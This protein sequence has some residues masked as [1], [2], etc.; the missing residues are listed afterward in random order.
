MKGITNELLHKLSSDSLADSLASP[1][2]LG[3]LNASSTSK[4][5][6][7]ETSFV[8]QS[9]E[10]LFDELGVQRLQSIRPVGHVCPPTTEQVLHFNT[11][12]VHGQVLAVCL[13][14]SRL[15]I[16]QLH[17]TASPS[18]DADS[19]ITWT[20][21]AEYTG[22]EFRKVDHF[23]SDRKIFFVLAKSG[24][25]MPLLR[26]HLN[27]L[28][29][30]RLDQQ[31][32]SSDPSTI[33]IWLPRTW[34]SNQQGGRHLNAGQTWNLAV[35]NSMMG[36]S[37][38]LPTFDRR[39]KR[40][41]DAESS[42][43]TLSTL[44]LPET[45]P[46][47][48]TNQSHRSV[49]AD[50]QPSSSNAH[51]SSTTISAHSSFRSYISLMYFDSV[52]N[53]FD[54]YDRVS[55]FLV[56]DLCTF[57]INN[58]D[59]M[60][61][62]NYK[63]GLNH[64]QVDSELFK[65]DPHE[66]KWKSIQKIRTFGAVA[67]EVFSLFGKQSQEAEHFLVVANNH[68]IN[69][70]NEINYEVNSVIYKFHYDQF[71][72]FQCI[73][74]V[75]AW[76][77]RMIQPINEQ[78]DDLDDYS[79]SG[80]WQPSRLR[81]VADA[82]TSR[83]VLAVASLT[84]VQLYQYNGWKFVVINHLSAAQHSESLGPSLPVHHRSYT[85]QLPPH[86]SSH[87]AMLND[88][89]ASGN[90]LY[91]F[92]LGDQLHLLASNRQHL[93]SANC[94]RLAFEAQNQLGAWYES[95][96]QWCD[97]LVHRLSIDVNQSLQPLQ[98]AMNRTHLIDS[99]TPI[100]LPELRLL[101]GA[102]FQRLTAPLVSDRANRRNFSDII[103]TQLVR[104]E[105]LL[106]SVHL[107]QGRLQQSLTNVLRLNSP[108]T[109]RINSPVE[110]D[111]VQMQCA[112]TN[113]C[114]LHSLQ[115][116]ALNGRPLHR[117]S[118][119]ALRL[120]RDERVWGPVAMDRL[121]AQ[122][123]DV[124]GPVNNRLVSSLLTR[125]GRHHVAAPVHFRSIVRASNV[126]A[127]SSVNNRRFDA[128]TV[129]LKSTNQTIRAPL[130]LNAA[131]IQGDLSVTGQINQ[132]PL[133]LN[134]IINSIVTDQSNVSILA[135]KTFIGPV[136]AEHITLGPDAL[137]NGVSLTSLHSNLVWIH[138]DQVVTSA[139]NFTDVHVAGNLNVAST[140]NG[141]VF[142]NDDLILAN[143]TNRLMAPKRF[144]RSLSA[145][146]VEIAASLNQLPLVD[147]DLDLLYRHQ[148]QRIVGRKKFIRGLHVGG[149][150]H[151]SGTVDGVK[152]QTF[153][154][155]L[156]ALN[157]TQAL[158]GT[159]LVHGDVELLQ[160]LQVDGQLNQVDWKH[161]LRTAIP[162]NATTLNSFE[163]VRFKHL[164]APQLHTPSLNRIPIAQYLL[165]HQPQHVKGRTVFTAGV[166]LTGPTNVT[167]FN[168]I[169]LASTLQ[170]TDSLLRDAEQKVTG[171]KIIEGDL[172]VS[173]LSARTLNGLPM[174]Q[175]F[176]LHSDQTITAPIRF[177]RA[178]IAGNMTT[179]QIDSLH[180]LNNEPF[181]ALINNS[182]QYDAP[183]TITARYQ[184]KQLRVPPST[185]FKVS[186]INR[187]D[188]NQLWKQ[189]VFA[190]GPNVQTVFSPITFSN[191]TKAQNTEFVATLGALKPDFL[192]SGLVRN[193]LP[194]EHQSVSGNLRVTGNLTVLDELI[195]DSGLL[196]G[197]HL[198]SFA[199]SAV[200]LDRPIVWSSPISFDSLHVRNGPVQVAGPVNELRVPQQLALRHRSNQTLF[201]PKSFASVAVNDQLTSSTP[202][203]NDVNLAQ[204]CQ[205]ALRRNNS[206]AFVLHEPTTILGNLRVHSFNVTGSINR[207]NMHQLQ[208]QFLLPSARDLPGEKSSVLH[209]T[210]HK[211]I[212]RLELFAPS[213]IV[214]YGPLSGIDL[215]ALASSYLSLSRPQKVTAPIRV[216]QSVLPVQ[217]F[218]ALG[219][220][221]VNRLLN[222][223]D[224]QDL[225]TNSLRNDRQQVINAPY[226]FSGPVRMMSGASI[227]L[228]TVNQVRLNQDLALRTRSINVIRSPVHFVQPLT[229]QHATTTAGSTIRHLT[230]RQISLDVGRFA[231]SAVFNDPTD[232]YVSGRK[233]FDELIV[234]D[235]VFNGTLLWNGLPF[236]L[237]VVLRDHPSLNITLTGPLQLNGAVRIDKSIRLD[238]RLNGMHL[239]SMLRD[240]VLKD[241]DSNVITGHKLWSGGLTIRDLRVA[242]SVAGFNFTELAAKLDQPSFDFNG[243]SRVLK[244]QQTHFDRITRSLDMLEDSNEA[245]EDDQQPS[246]PSL[247]DQ[248]ASHDIRSQL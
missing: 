132:Q 152:L 101:G 90:Q 9:S 142:P 161:L 189:L 130:L 60:V 243:T 99:D 233:H 188:L 16:G 171:H 172:H 246:A 224:L 10:P 219:S 18:S 25:G 126:Q 91:S 84:G 176:T 94:F 166:M 180:T 118:E 204:L 96:L 194:V 116:D 217:H 36:S 11:L 61:V 106:S 200:R 14:Q 141:I 37:S 125:S 158:N 231:R 184:V 178:S 66:I 51:P 218:R 12:R 119:R 73:S 82:S 220:L 77:V 26:L 17:S 93:R 86:Y 4:R 143:R 129:L 112:G 32:V 223:F 28:R 89:L 30:I 72:P 34:K 104:L 20:A 168:D 21:A 248:I 135:E 145:N 241:S 58:Y 24:V 42:N 78:N 234:D 163:Q 164:N 64:H 79:A 15:S 186:R 213:L 199:A 197:V 127:Q 13:T 191:L 121:V 109:Q 47:P 74:T 155:T 212:D 50:L 203:F 215:R 98:Q 53:Y 6:K 70:Q 245:E 208:Q 27:P 39:K 136:Q 228:D 229:T 181:A 187:V 150:S 151:V 138:R 107:E 29:L 57:T 202:L 5:L 23:I 153:E 68:D 167:R 22:R 148:P 105:R 209:V 244:Y 56:K 236:D 169:P 170:A 54:E 88:M 123:F 207:W 154:R 210:G 75:G 124:S 137:I 97:R 227:R 95:S 190:N 33:S 85:S 140:L 225:A 103:V 165:R 117:L 239:S 45:S 179:L 144:H 183:Q 235:L 113:G 2:L 100:E 81:S 185:N 114:S 110:F 174:N 1:P 43:G 201:G 46:A 195:V 216:Q 230:D 139:I 211:H 238:G 76:S 69:A 7:R 221:H 156:R 48:A 182:L 193:G 62:I 38:E 83:Q 122:Q 44:S 41:T 232:Y 8:G 128:N 175:L 160:P 134:Q 162:L 40:S 80:A 59:Y 120:D 71:I 240:L 35:A 102:G 192:V 206:H 131:S 65:L 92:E 157:R 196:D 111:H 49:P 19:F 3:S 52:S 63:S 147:G 146:H 177:D 173:R 115:T 159:V 198:S 237:S 205:N 222:S 242:S 67:C 31:T 108:R 247:T 133:T 226:V 87:Q 55:S 149:A 214:G